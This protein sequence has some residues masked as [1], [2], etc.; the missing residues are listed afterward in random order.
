MS[1]ADLLLGN[2]RLVTRGRAPVPRLPHLEDPRFETRRY[3]GPDAPPADAPELF[4]FHDVL[5]ELGYRASFAPNESSA[6]LLTG[7]W[8]LG[9]AGPYV[10]IDGFRDTVVLDR[11]RPGS[12]G[13]LDHLRAHRSLV[14][15]QPRPL[16]GGELVVGCAQL[17]PGCQGRFAPE[18]LILM[19]TFF[20]RPYH[21]MLLVDPRDGTL[22]FYARTE[23][24]Q[25]VNVP[26]QVVSVRDEDQAS[27]G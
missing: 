14:E 20:A 4:I 16:T 27:Q 10:E 1:L 17:R 25:I 9:P 11:G 23:T 22:G 2:T 18:D 6:C 7:G 15:P 5:A 19:N 12:L 24:A 26:L 21:V 13:M 8:Y 3:G